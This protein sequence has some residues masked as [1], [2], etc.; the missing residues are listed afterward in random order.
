VSGAAPPDNSLYG[1]V[2]FEPSG[3][4]AMGQVVIQIQDGKIVPV[5]AS[6][7]T[8]AKALFPAPRWGQRK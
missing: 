6:G 5:Y 7:R 4:I 3:Q 1:R 8:L 2:K